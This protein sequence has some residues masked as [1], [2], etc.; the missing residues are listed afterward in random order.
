[1]R[2]KDSTMAM[3]VGCPDPR[4]ILPAHKGTPPGSF[5][6]EAVVDEAFFIV[7]QLLT[8]IVNV[9][10][11]PEDLATACA[12]AVS[13]SIVGPMLIYMAAFPSS[14]IRNAVILS[15]EINL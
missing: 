2:G 10:M 11:L 5:N 3:V 13:H 6:Y 14:N 8:G 7:Y 15:V 4:G 12:A 9:H 1:M